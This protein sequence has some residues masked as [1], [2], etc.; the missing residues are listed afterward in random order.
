MVVFP[1]SPNSHI[2]AGPHYT[3]AFLTLQVGNLL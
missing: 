2:V 3:A 1:A